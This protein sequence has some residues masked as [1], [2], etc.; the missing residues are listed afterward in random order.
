MPVSKL[1]LIQTPG[2]LS[3]ARWHEQLAQ[4]VADIEK[5]VVLYFANANDRDTRVAKAG[6]SLPIGTTGFMQDSLTYVYWSGTAWIADGVWTTWVPTLTN[7]TLGSGGVVTARW[8]KTGKMA[9]FFF[10]FVFGTGSAV[11]SLPT[12]TLP[13]TP[14]SQYVASV[15]LGRGDLIDTGVAAYFALGRLVGPSSLE[16]VYLGTSGVHSVVSTSVPFTWGSTD[17]LVINGAG[18]EIA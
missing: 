5:N 9:D 8:R 17:R 14:A 18:I 1:A 13:F 2:A 4:L 11:G 15:V 7:L 6:V 3:Q 16:V 12:F 10:S